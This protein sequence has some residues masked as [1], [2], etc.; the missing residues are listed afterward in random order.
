MKTKMK[1]TPKKIV[2]K[3]TRKIRKMRKNKKRGGMDRLEKMENLPKATNISTLNYGY[4]SDI[5]IV[6]ATVDSDKTDEE[7]LQ[8]FYNDL[9]NKDFPFDKDL[10]NNIFVEYPNFDVN[11]QDR[12]E[13]TLLDVAIEEKM[14]NLVEK[15][16]NRSN[17][18]AETLQKGLETL[19]RMEKRNKKLTLTDIRCREL[20][21]NKLRSI[22]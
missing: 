12:I 18:T 13:Q 14:P 7:K 2:Y 9:R 3:K 10:L 21:T 6:N 5:P 19:Y 11:T 20:I 22:R 17:T 16:V 4:Q 8:E 15:I 1:K